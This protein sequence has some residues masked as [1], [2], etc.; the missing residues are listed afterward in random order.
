VPR[1]PL[2]AATV[3]RAGGDFGRGPRAAAATGLVVG[4]GAVEGS[5]RPEPT[6]EGSDERGDD[7]RRAEW[8]TSDAE[9]RAVERQPDVE[10][11]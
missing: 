9:E 4:D 11:S 6:W 3:E 5:W 8:A 1:R 2:G 10:S 7:E